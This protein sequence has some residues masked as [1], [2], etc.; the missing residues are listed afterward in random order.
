M[1]SDLNSYFSKTLEKG[2]SI[3]SLF[4][5]DHSRRTLSEISRLTGINKTSTYRLVNT[6]VILGFLSK[7]SRGRSLRLGPKALLSGH[8]IIQ[9]Y[10]L[11]HMVKPLI[12]EAHTLCNVTIDSTLIDGLTLLALYR[13]EASSTLF[14]RQPLASEDLHARAMGK[15]VL[16]R[17][18][19]DDL[20]A[21]LAKAPF[22]KFTPN[23]IDQADILRCEIENSCNR[24]Y[25]I[26]NEEYLQ[27]LICIGAPLINFQTNKVTG[28]ISFDLPTS[29]YTLES[30]ITKYAGQVTKLANNI[31]EL[32]TMNES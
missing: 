7:D 4:D 2:L 27:G 30:V 12:D 18:D 20:E 32:V 31:S 17:M 22:K 28:A 29:Q 26:N 19:K 8:T 11:L 21:F 14:F 24:G 15:A 16:S 25:S 10:E 5:K 13:R 3:I 6:L 9:G 1:G 23:T